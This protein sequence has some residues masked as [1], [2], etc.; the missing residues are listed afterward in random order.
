MAS[1]AWLL[2]GKLEKVRLLNVFGV[3]VVAAVLFYIVK[4]LASSSFYSVLPQFVIF[5]VLICIAYRLNFIETI[6]GSLVTLVVFGVAQ[7]TIINTMF[8]IVGLTGQDFDENLYVVVASAMV[9]L[10]V[11]F[12][13]CYV[14]YKA[15]INIH[16]LRQK[17][18]DKLYISRIRFLIL[19]LAFGYLN[20]F[21]IYTLFFNNINVSETTINKVLIIL[22][23]AFN[24]LFTVVLVKSVFKMGNVIKREEE[25][26]RKYDGRE[27]IQNINYI[28]SLIDSKEYEEVKRFLE[29]MKKDVDDKIVSDK[30]STNR[31]ER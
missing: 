1:F 10:M 2:L 29:S 9:Y 28:C 21:I 4:S 30:N 5:T 3:G 20:L 6:I 12:L 13:M 27:I 23:L 22:C 16:Y 26:K 18:K 25:L 14:F 24:I 7:G 17:T 15:K 11:M 19:Q 31:T 8:V